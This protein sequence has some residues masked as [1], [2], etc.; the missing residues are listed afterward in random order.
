MRPLQFLES[1]L[2]RMCEHAERGYPHEVV[3]ILAGDAKRHLVRRVEPLVNERAEQAHRRYEV[4]GLMLVR[5]Q[6]RLEAE[7]LDILG[8]YHSHPDHSSRYSDYDR[9]H[10]LPNLSYV[11]VSVRAGLAM[12]VASWR[13]REDRTAMD[14][15]PWVLATPSN[16]EIHPAIPRNRPTPDHPPSRRSP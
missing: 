3:G 9:D 12:D 8:Y 11:I 4:S 16:P 7:G 14:A 10:A 2:Q 15:E 6:Q 13:L 5:A 1:E